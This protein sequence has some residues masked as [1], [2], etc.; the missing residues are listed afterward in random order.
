MMGRKTTAQP[1]PAIKTQVA[2]GESKNGL[3]VCGFVSVEVVI[4]RCGNHSLQVRACLYK[5]KM[6]IAMHVLDK[7]KP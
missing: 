7:K 4:S 1:H 5:H 6:D 2:K 3:G